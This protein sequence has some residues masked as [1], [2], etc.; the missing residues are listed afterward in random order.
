MP[1]KRQKKDILYEVYNCIINNFKKYECNNPKCDKDKCKVHSHPFGDIFPH[2]SK[3]YFNHD[4]NKKIES[5][6]D[7]TIQKSNFA[8]DWNID[9]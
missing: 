6:D 7:M 1:Y 8:Y 9:H 5:E 3:F 2:R 4:I